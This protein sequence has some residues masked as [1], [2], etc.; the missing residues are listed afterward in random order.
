M[1][2]IRN[3]AVIPKKPP[4]QINNQWTFQTK[5]QQ[6]LRNIINFWSYSLIWGRQERPISQ[7]RECRTELAGSVVQLYFHSINCFS[8][9]VWNFFFPQRGARGRHTF[10]PFFGEG[11]LFLE[12]LSVSGHLVNKRLK[13]ISSL[14]VHQ[15]DSDPS[16]VCVQKIL[17]YL[18]LQHATL[19]SK[20]DKHF[21]FKEAHS[22][23]ANSS[24]K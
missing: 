18:S 24:V 6:K 4:I 23:T 8:L 3:C 14:L 11:L 13:Q 15:C 19:F 16:Q 12:S 5:T 7:A 21:F 20:Y 9:S 17:I 10:A 22:K 1:Y 2:R